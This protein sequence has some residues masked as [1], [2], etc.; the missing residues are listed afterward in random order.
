M[1]HTEAVPGTV[2]CFIPKQFRE[3]QMLYT[4]AVQRRSNA[5]C[6]AGKGQMH[7]TEANQQKG[8]I[9][10]ENDVQ[11]KNNVA[12]ALPLPQSVMVAINPTAIAGSDALYGSS[13][14][15]GQ[16][17]YTE[18]VLGRVKCVILKQC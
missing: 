16:M 6:S 15:K 3:G 12:S 8:S 18:A 11:G 7:Y 1:L 2:K 14:R 10:Q 5:L 9:I 13:A 4:E 17:L